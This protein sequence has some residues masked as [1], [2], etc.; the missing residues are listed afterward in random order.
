MKTSYADNWSEQRDRKQASCEHPSFETVRY[1][2]LFNTHCINCGLIVDSDKLHEEGEVKEILI[3]S[4][5]IKI[6]N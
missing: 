5:E 2:K 6:D 3:D 1:G 4:D